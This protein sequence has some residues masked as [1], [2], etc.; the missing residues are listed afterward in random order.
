[1]LFNRLDKIFWVLKTSIFPPLFRVKSR[2]RKLIRKILSE[3][4]SKNAIQKK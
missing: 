2:L 3:N 1:M 4:N